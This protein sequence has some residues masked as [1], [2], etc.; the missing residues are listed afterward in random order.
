MTHPKIQK[1]LRKKCAVNARDI[2]IRS[3][4]QTI[5]YYIFYIECVCHWYFIRFG[6]EFTTIFHNGT[7][8]VSR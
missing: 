2:D 8:S 5:N 4:T 3:L 6:L 1:A 7:D